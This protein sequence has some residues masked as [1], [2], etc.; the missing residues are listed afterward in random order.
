MT[1]LSLVQFP[2]S[3]CDFDCISAMDR[4]FGLK[5]KTVWH[6]E[7]SLPKTDYLIIPGGFSFGDYIRS[8]SLASHSNIMPAVKTFADNGGYI[9]G[10]CNGFQI[11][12][13]AGILPGALLQNRDG[14]FIC[15]YV[16]LNAAQQKSVYSIPIAHG[17][18][19]YFVNSDGLKKLQYENQIAYQYSDSSGKIAETENPNGS[20]ENIAGIYSTNK[21]VLGLMPHP[22]RA[23]D[24]RL[25][26]SADGKKIW[27]EFFAKQ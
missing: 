18:G 20:T 8:G 27:Q 16:Y 22:E 5:V 7:T 13:E 12:T 11:L 19:R 24:I 1:M 15:K 9:I 10:I 4:Y 2:G 23:V 26:A 17:E 25:G 21:R 14:K 6:T 3:N